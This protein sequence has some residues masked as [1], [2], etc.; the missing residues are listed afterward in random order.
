[1]WVLSV[2]ASI[3]IWLGKIFEKILVESGRVLQDQNGHNTENWTA[4]REVPM[5]RLLSQFTPT[6][7]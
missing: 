5:W 1:M 7:T 2:A 3:K 4:S 6:A